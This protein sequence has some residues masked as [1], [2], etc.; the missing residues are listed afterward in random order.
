METWLPSR[1]LIYS[2]VE[3][4]TLLLFVINSSFLC[5]VR[6]TYLDLFIDLSCR[7]RRQRRCLGVEAHALPD[8]P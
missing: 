4:N 3:Q 7:L 1:A 2:L 8:A 6:D 5:N